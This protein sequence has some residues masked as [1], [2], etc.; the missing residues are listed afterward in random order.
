MQ[1]RLAPHES[2]Q[3][4]AAT[5]QQV[6]PGESVVVDDPDLAKGL[7]EQT[8]KWLP[9]AKARKTSTDKDGD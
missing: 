7:L 8:D 5:G 9:A 2:A 3:V 1:I 4:I 6:E